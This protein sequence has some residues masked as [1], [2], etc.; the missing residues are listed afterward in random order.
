MIFLDTDVCIE[1]LS[2][3]QQF[4]NLI[5]VLGTAQFGITAPS[6]FELYHGLYKLKYLKKDV[7]PRKFEKLL[8]DLN[9]FI[10]RLNIFP[11]TENSAEMSAQLHMQLKGA[12]Q[13]IDIFDC[14]IAGIILANDFTQ[15]LTYNIDHFE[16][17]P[18]LAL[19]K[20]DRSEV[21]SNK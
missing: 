9:A 13:E 21:K 6:I 3:K 15:I 14:L 7:A 8:H 5:E 19:V 11:L 1:I 12:G 2:G 10:N 20:L 18:V 17:I 16:R 4:K